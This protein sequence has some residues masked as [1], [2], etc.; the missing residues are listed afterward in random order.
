MRKYSL[1]LFAHWWAYIFTALLSTL[2]LFTHDLIGTNLT[3]IYPAFRF[4]ISLLYLVS[5]FNVRSLA[6]NIFL[7]ALF[8]ALIE[9]PAIII[10][11]ICYKWQRIGRRITSSSSLISTGVVLFIII[12]LIQYDYETATTVL[13]LLGKGLVTI[14]F[15]GVSVYSSEI[16]PTEVRNLG[17]G[18][19]GLLFTVAGLIAPF[20]GDIL[21]SLLTLYM[22]LSMPSSIMKLRGNIV[23]SD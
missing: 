14:T 5:T 23:L 1:I 8:S 21:V 22:C 15:S 12:P 20:M 19:C 17:L 18:I 10:C 4:T 16:F 6:G 11:Y 9:I 3:V 7:N 2:C 13:S